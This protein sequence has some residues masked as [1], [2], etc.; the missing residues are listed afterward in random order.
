MSKFIIQFVLLL[1]L[2]CYFI[3]VYA[4]E[5]PEKINCAT[6]NFPPYAFSEGKQLKG[7]EIDIF[8]ELENRTGININIDIMP[9]KRMLAYARV[10]KIKC[11]F[12]VFKTDERV[13]YLHYTSVPIHESSLMLYVHRDN[14]FEYEY[15]S[16]QNLL[17][18][19]FGL[20]RGFASTPKFDKAVTQ[21]LFNHVEVNSVEQLLLL[22]SKKRIDAA[23]ISKHVGDY[24]LKR[25][26]ITDV[27][28]IDSPLA[29]NSAYIAFSKSMNASVL[30]STFNKALAEM[31]A[32]GTYDQI[33][34]KH[35]YT[36]PNKH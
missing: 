34:N 24:Q 22:L 25:L 14:Y 35:T 28:A 13:K 31:I 23:I 11:V 16:Y 17:G 8:S 1:C 33:F 27:V 15:E 6:N 2:S 7:I 36:Q 21:R 26:N 19:T 5:I 12:S 32:D 30:V 29:F 18:K 10:G 4:K 9:F 3:D 20:I